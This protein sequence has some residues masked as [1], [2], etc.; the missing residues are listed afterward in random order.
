M[1]LMPSSALEAQ[2]RHAFAGTEGRYSDYPGAARSQEVG[3]Q[4][5][6][7]P[8]GHRYSAGG[9]QSDRDLAASIEKTHGTACAR[10]GGYLPQPR[11]RLARHSA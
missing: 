10:G 9:G 5:A 3:N 4:G 6:V 8:G 11:T 7:C 2:L 1:P